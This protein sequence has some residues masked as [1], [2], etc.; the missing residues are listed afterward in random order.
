MSNFKKIII[1]IMSLLIL[2][3][4]GV[5]GYVQYRLKDVTITESTYE[6]KIEK[7]KGV[8]NVLLLGTDGRSGENT[9]RTDSMMIL[10]IDTNNDNLKLTSLARDTYVNI[11]GVG[12]NKLNAAYAFGKVD[13][14]FE[15]IENEFGIGLD[16]YA[17][18]DFT[19]LMDII[20]TLGGVEV[21]VQQSELNQLRKYTQECY[22]L[23]KNTNKGELQYVQ[24]AGIQTLNGYQ[25]LAYSRIRY[26]DNAIKRDERQR[27]VLNA[28]INKYKDTPI[29]KFNSLIDSVT[30]YITTNL[31]AKDIIDLGLDGLN[32]VSGKSSDSLLKEGS[33]P[34]TDEIHSK[35]G[36]YGN[37]GWVWLYDKNS[38]VVLKDFIYNDINM[39]ENKY[40]QDNSNISLNY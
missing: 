16:K 15:T 18:V 30:P 25:A 12:N 31:T 9:G 7:V 28:I 14:L 37:A 22:N 1:C 17:M 2:I 24:N 4:L 36:I 29:T 38:T 34:I 39:D 3:P 19:S 11:P 33:F 35:G 20:F 5:F 21:D 13:L 10:T 8:T 6:S 27:K 26:N 32:V 40:L 23:C